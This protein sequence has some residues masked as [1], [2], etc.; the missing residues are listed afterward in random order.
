[1]NKRLLISTALMTCAIVGGFSKDSHAGEY[2]PFWNFS[3]EDSLQN[4]ANFSTNNEC[5]DHFFWN[6][7]DESEGADAPNRMMDVIPNTP[8]WNNYRNSSLPCS[9]SEYESD[10]E[11][12]S[13]TEVVQSQSKKR[14]RLQDEGDSTNLEEYSSSKRLKKEEV[15]TVLQN[16]IIRNEN[17]YTLDFD[18][19]FADFPL[20]LGRFV[21]AEYLS[22]MHNEL[23]VLPFDVFTLKKLIKLELG[24]NDFEVL[25]PQIS[26]LDQLTDLELCNNNFEIFPVEVCTLRSLIRLS[27]GGN[28]LTAL[29]SEIGQL[30]NLEKLDIGHFGSNDVNYELDWSENG[31]TILPPEI[32]NLRALT[33]LNL[34]GQGLRNLPREI[35]NLTN[36]T[37]LDLN[38]NKLTTLTPAIGQLVML[39][40]FDLGVNELADLPREIGNLRALTRFQLYNN[41]LFELP[42]E[43]GNLLNIIVL[44]LED[45]PILPQGSTENLWGRQELRNCFGDRCTLDDVNNVATMQRYTTQESVYEQL[46]AQSPRIN[47][48]ML[49]EAKMM[50]IPGESIEDGHEF[51]QL[52]RKLVSSL[53]LTRENE[54]DYL[55]FELLA[56]DFG[57][58]ERDNN[59][60]NADKIFRSVF[61]RLTGYFK[62]LYNL[63]LEQGE[64]GGWRM[65]EDKI[66]ALKKALSYIVTTLTGLEDSQQR[67]CLFTLFTDGMLHCPTGQSEGI[68]TVVLALLEGKTQLSAD[69]EEIVKLNF[70]LKKNAYFKMA[71]LSKT[72]HM[73][74]NVHVISDYSRR[75]KDELGLSNVIGFQEQMG[76]YGN[77]PFSN[78]HNNVLQVFYEYVTPQRMV[79]WFM[80]KVQPRE[81]MQ[82]Q[83]RLATL[84]SQMTATTSS[85]EHRVLGLNSL[86]SVLRQKE[87]ELNEIK[88][89][90]NQKK[91]KYRLEVNILEA[92]IDNVKTLQ[93]RTYSEKESEGAMDIINSKLHEIQLLKEK[94]KAAITFHPISTQVVM[95]Y[96]QKIG[97][98][99]Q[100][101]GWWKSY[102]SANPEEDSLSELTHGGALKIITH[103]DYVIVDNDEIFAG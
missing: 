47:R 89:I 63:P 90:T 33:Y 38:G 1:M 31:L 71:I 64:E 74:Q 21:N 69:L 39:T 86:A 50:E 65:Y 16:R 92:Q 70:A 76:I 5:T 28:P 37:K 66:P 19:D 97:A 88:A 49:K 67:A 54:P 77:D 78:N 81:T 25:S 48:A 99:T 4:I 36:L 58:Q 10:D 22:L 91:T 46:D 56:G 27:I 30:E 61:S 62:S 100:I 18:S 59:D 52:F 23:T 14:K 32:G 9:E 55:S 95:N 98:K 94:I 103:L 34:T 13:D 12:D 84:G 83:N 29:P 6:S 42:R 11:S 75:L 26:R 85:Q 51:L 43:I 35:G 53:N 20:T 40:E 44:E 57:R 96:L 24:F 102:F 8:L 45:C 41:P 15:F 72:A 101:E 60:S 87:I 79:N 2:N 3:Q 80:E 73:G 7:D 68:D 82:L 93:E 17:V